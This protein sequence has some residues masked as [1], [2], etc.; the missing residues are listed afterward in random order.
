MALLH[1][2][3]ATVRLFLAGYANAPLQG[4]STGLDWKTVPMYALFRVGEIET[5]PGHEYIIGLNPNCYHQPPVLKSIHG[6]SASQ[7]ND[8]MQA[9]TALPGNARGPV[10]LAYH[11]ASCSEVGKHMQGGTTIL[12]IAVLVK[13]DVLRKMAFSTQG[14]FGVFLERKFLDALLKVQENQAKERRLAYN[15]KKPHTFCLPVFSIRKQTL[16]ID[17]RGN[18]GDLR[19]VVEALKKWEYA[20]RCE[21]ETRW[22]KGMNRII[23]ASI[24]GLRRKGGERPR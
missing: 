10:V 5:P 13:L 2:F 16:H 23:G 17:L 19:F 11:A 21:R 18:D 15:A 6:L 9:V 4:S 20:F 3:S 1:E 12:R 24:T 14:G 8:F 7:E 22:R